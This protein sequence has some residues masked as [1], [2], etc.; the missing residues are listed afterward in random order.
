[1]PGFVPGLPK[2]RAALLYARR[3]HKGQLR[4][5]D[6]AP[7]IEHPREVASLLY[8]A[9]APDHVIAAGALHDVIEKTDTDA[10]ELRE[11]FGARVAALVLA[12]SEDEHI[13]PYARRKAA[14][15]E[16]AAL[17]GEEALAVFAA[18]KVSKA[19]ELRLHPEA[20][21]WRRRLDFY[22]DCLRLLEQRLPESLLVRELDTELQSITRARMTERVPASAS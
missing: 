8:S 13:R 12:V 5:M 20:R 4:K 18:D 16:Q 15:R 14:L 3:A 7:F 21:H 11:R 22:S 19:R 1:M 17:A 10:Q 6:G 9:G 2:T